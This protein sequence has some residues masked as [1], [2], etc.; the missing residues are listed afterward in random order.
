V[1]GTSAGV[2]FPIPKSGIEAIVNHKLRYAG[3]ALSQVM[4]RAVVST[5]GE[6]SYTRV[7]Y[8]SLYQYNNSDLKPSERKPNISSFYLEKKLAPARVAGEM[9]LAHSY[10]N[11]HD[12]DYQTIWIYS[13]GQRRVRLAPELSYDSPQDDGLRTSDE[14]DQYNGGTDRYNWKLLGKR[15]MYVPYNTYKMADKAVRYADLLTPNHLNPNYMRYELHRVWMVEA[16]LKNGASHIYSKRVFYLDEDTWQVLVQE[17]Y[18][19]R[20]Q[21]WRVSEAY[22]MAVPELGAFISYSDAYFDIQTG[23]YLVNI[24]TNEEKERLRVIKRTP[25]N[26]SP[27][28]LRTLGTR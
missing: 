21:L 25:D 22:M 23:R 13:P 2:P 4:T 1:I 3:N 11:K 26:Y 24:L 27:Q 7:E 8:E 28:N 20:G 12:S 6:V 15:E 18:D 5:G 16:T 14:L 10:V 19:S 17:K 9:A